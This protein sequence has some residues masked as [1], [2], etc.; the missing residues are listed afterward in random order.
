MKVGGMLRLYDL[1]TFPSASN[2]S[3]CQEHTKPM[4]ENYNQPAVDSLSSQYTDIY[5]N[6]V[7]Q[8]AQQHFHD[9]STS[10][11]RAQL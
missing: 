1:N 11:W 3:L 2:Q 4:L 6:L 10:D 5:T 7:F 9:T 8:Y